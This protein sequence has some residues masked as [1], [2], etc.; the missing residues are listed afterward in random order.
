MP[1]NSL[2]APFNELISIKQAADFHDAFN[3][4]DLFAVIRR[5]MTLDLQTPALLFPALSLL[6]LAFTNKFLAIANLIRQLSSDYAENKSHSTLSQ[7]VTLRRRLA[8]IRWMQAAGIASI[9][10]CV[11]TMFLVYRGVQ[12]GAQILFGTA[13]VLL[14]ASLVFAMIEIFLSAGAL[15]VVLSDLEKKEQEEA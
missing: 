13:L 1:Q 12:V 11:L 8:I 6:I 2:F 3:R 14:L 4:F 7:I 10:F 5:M 9:F 15:D